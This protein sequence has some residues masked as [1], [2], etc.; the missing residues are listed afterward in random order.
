M[1]SGVEDESEIWE[2]GVNGMKNSFILLMIALASILVFATQVMAEE[3]S[4]LGEQQATEEM[5]PV[6]STPGQGFDEMVPAV[7]EQQQGAEEMAP[8]G[9]TM[10]QGSEEME[11]AASAPQEEEYVTPRYAPYVAPHRGHPY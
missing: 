11:S 2:K 3:E 1:T 10:Q 9:S 7:P 4:Y 6:T 5:G 8:S